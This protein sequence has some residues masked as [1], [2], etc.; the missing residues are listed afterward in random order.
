MRKEKQS[1]RQFY[2]TFGWAKDEEGAY[3]DAVA[4]VDNR[5]VLESYSSRAHL[6][7][8][9]FLK[10]RG[11][12]FLD[13]GSGPIAHPALIQDAEG[14][15]RHVCVDFSAVALAEARS[16]LGRR[17]LFVVGDLACLPFRDSTFDTTACHHVLYHVPPDE[18][19]AVL[20]EFHRTLNDG[21]R[22][23]VIYR[24]PDTVLKRLARVVLIVE[25]KLKRPKVLMKHMLAQVPG[26]RRLKRMFIESLPR[27]EPAPV[28]ELPHLYCMPHDYRRLRALFAK[29]WQYKIRVWR[30]VDDSFTRAFVPDNGWGRFVMAVIWRLECLF[31][32]VLMRMGKYP[33]IVMTKGSAGGS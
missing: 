7:M 4:F 27:P 6:R 1:V 10:P 29:E 32:C 5:P 17:G 33:L 26:L 22:C 19:G 20:C 16:K 30:S 25:E 24:W 8:R 21:G 11:R 23:V 13:A 14:F 3:N 12:Y 28:K 31:P 2:D 9:S 15:D 18:Q